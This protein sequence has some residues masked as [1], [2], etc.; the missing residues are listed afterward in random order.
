MDDIHNSH[1][2]LFYRF[3]PS[4][5]ITTEDSNP[6]HY[7]EGETFE[8]KQP[9]KIPVHQ[10]LPTSQVNLVLGWFSLNQDYIKSHSCGDNQSILGR[11]RYH[12]HVIGKN[13]ALIVFDKF[14]SLTSSTLVVFSVSIGNQ[15]YSM[16]K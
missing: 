9:I 2:N 15:S 6:S 1:K 8:F 11:K 7:V 14:F 5:R 4:P 12:V 10:K 3:N 16:F 13:N